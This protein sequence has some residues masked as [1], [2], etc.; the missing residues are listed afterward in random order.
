VRRTRP[1]TGASSRCPRPDLL[2]S[3]LPDPM[4]QLTPEVAA[5][6]SLPDGLDYSTDVRDVPVVPGSKGYGSERGVACGG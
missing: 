2:N 4:P 5:T 6:P 1:R 3:D